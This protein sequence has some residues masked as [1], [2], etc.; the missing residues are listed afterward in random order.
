MSSFLYEQNQISQWLKEE[1]IARAASTKIID[2]V[3]R[4]RYYIRAEHY[5]D[6]AWSLAESNDHA[7][8]PSEIW[9]S[10]SHR[11]VRIAA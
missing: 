2:P 3:E 6:Y 9:H 4:D 1:A 10:N 7:F 11:A 8:I 5:A